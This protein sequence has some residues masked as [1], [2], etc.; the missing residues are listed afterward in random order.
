LTQ[1]QSTLVEQQSKAEWENISLQEE[2]DEEKAQLQ[3]RKDQLLVEKLEV[4]ER[5]HKALRSMTVIEVKIEER[6]PQWVA[7]LEELIQ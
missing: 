2:W 4:H 3:Q 5:V 1:V 7:Q 6:V